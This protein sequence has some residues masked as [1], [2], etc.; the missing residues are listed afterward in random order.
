MQ[1]IYR[2]ISPLSLLLAYLMLN[3][4]ARYAFLTRQCEKKGDS[5]LLL[6]DWGKFLSGVMTII[7]IFYVYYHLSGGRNTINFVITMVLTPLAVLILLIVY[8][9]NLDELRGRWKYF[10]WPKKT[11]WLLVLCFISPIIFNGL[12]IYL[13]WVGYK[14]LAYYAFEMRYWSLLIGPLFGLL[15]FLYFMFRGI[16]RPQLKVARK[17][18]LIESADIT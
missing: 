13:K 14:T 3:F 9:S 10:T 17:T 15:Y 6:K 8:W 7:A 12:S 1:V 2:L 11:F 16:R 5:M 4:V 18:T